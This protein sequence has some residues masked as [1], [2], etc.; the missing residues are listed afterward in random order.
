[1]PG[2][3]GLQLTGKLGEVIRKSAQLGLSLV[4]SHAFE[5]GIASLASEQFLTERDF[6]VHLLE[7][8]IGKEGPSV[9][10]TILLVFVSLFKAITPG[11]MSLMG[12]QE[13]ILAAHHAG[14]KTILAPAANC[15]NIEEN[16]QRGSRLGF[17][18]Y[19]WRM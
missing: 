14:L 13:K 8:S 3:G 6:R 7:G 18:L 16:G 10:R 15:A 4:K 9:G 2:R 19:M 17:I 12:L 5:L 1:M 11:E